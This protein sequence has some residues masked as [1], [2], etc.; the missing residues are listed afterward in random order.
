MA[1]NKRG[2]CLVSSAI[3]IGLLFALCILIY[4]VE[5]IANEL[6][7]LYTHYSCQLP[8]FDGGLCC[9]V[10]IDIKLVQEC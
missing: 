5:L 7:K 8:D 9:D 2:G 1:A 10:V 4:F 6:M 3:F